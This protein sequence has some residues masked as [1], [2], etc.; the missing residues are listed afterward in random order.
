MPP[1]WL[2]HA[3]LAGTASVL[4]AAGLTGC[5][6]GDRVA[7]DVSRNVVAAPA[8]M[9]VAPL[10][11]HGEGRGVSGC[12]VISPPAF[13][14]EEEAFQVIAETLHEHGIELRANDTPLPD[15]SLPRP[16]FAV[17]VDENGNRIRDRR[18]DLPFCIDGVD[19]ERHIAIE[20]ASVEDE[21]AIGGPWATGVMSTV[22][23]YDS[24]QVAGYLA[25]RAAE[26]RA[27][28]YCGVFY[29]PI[30]AMPPLSTPNGTGTEL[31]LELDAGSYEDQWR[32]R[33]RRALEQS[34]A[35]LRLQVQDFIAW[36][37]GQG[38]I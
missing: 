14:S 3:E 12:I 19:A 2:R 16:V 34:K 36:L 8:R 11:Q 5:T 35:D 22:Q 7:P 25:E 17:L 29:D 15:V 13:L 30:S 21:R 18:P 23:R 24:T 33:Q 37:K 9:I 26:S 38:V 31:E 32:A 27:A 10:F 1:A 4:L 20:Y 28:Y 6:Q